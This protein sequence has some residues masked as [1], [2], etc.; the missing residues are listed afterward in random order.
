MINRNNP[1][2]ATTLDND[3][4][5][6]AKYEFPNYKSCE[7]FLSSFRLEDSQIDPSI[8]FESILIEGVK[9]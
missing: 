9:I 6:L 7:E 4:R 3:G 8:E 1:V 5:I 2:V